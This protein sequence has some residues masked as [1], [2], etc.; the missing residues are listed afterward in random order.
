MVI[1]TLIKRCLKEQGR[2]IFLGIKY[3][4]GTSIPNN[5]KIYQIAKDYAYQ[6]V[7]K[8]PR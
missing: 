3:Q 1:L 2:Q 4:N 8:I 6:M 5:Y 7:L